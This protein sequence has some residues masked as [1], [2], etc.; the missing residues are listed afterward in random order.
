[1]SKTKLTVGVVMFLT[2]LV[3]VGFFWMARSYFAAI[4]QGAA[5]QAMPPPAQVVEQL[6]C[7]LPAPRGP[8]QP[9]VVF[10][11]CQRVYR[12]GLIL[13]VLLALGGLY[14]AAEGLT[15]DGERK[16]EQS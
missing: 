12:T 11:R 3:L 1:M 5:P 10:F 16:S 9:P 14:V 13:S 15:D 7:V 6:A 8:A 2:G 4:V